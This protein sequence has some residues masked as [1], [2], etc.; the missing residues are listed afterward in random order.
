[1]LIALKNFLRQPY[2]I[3]CT[4]IFRILNNSYKIALTTYFQSP[5]YVCKDLISGEYSHFSYGC[6]I[7][8]HVTVGKYVLCGPECVIGM[9]NHSFDKPGKPVIFSGQPIIKQTVI[10]DDVWIGQRVMIKSGVT[11]GEGAIVAMGSVVTKDVKPYTI[12]GGIP[13]KFLK[14]RF[15]NLDEIEKHKSFLKSKPKGGTYCR[16]FD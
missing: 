12:V 9:G 16:G 14:N 7:G 13:A 11:V 8:K 10:E 15:S 4:F 2:R 6:Y 1:M 3:I 5:K